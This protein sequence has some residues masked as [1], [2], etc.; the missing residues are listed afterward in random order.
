MSDHLSQWGAV[1][2][3]LLFTGELPA[4]AQQNS[5]VSIPITVSTDAGASQELTLGI[6]PEATT[7]IDSFLGE[8]ERPPLPPSSTFDARLI[9]DDL[10]ISGLGTG[11][12]TDFRPGSF[13]F[14]GTT[15]HELRYQPGSDANSVT[16]AWEMPSGVTGTLQDVATD[17]DEITVSMTGNGSVALENLSLMKLT[18]TLE[19]VGP[20]VSISGGRGEHTYDPP[21]PQPGTDQNP[22]GRL[23]LSADRDGATLCSLVVANEGPPPSGI[24][25]A[26]LWRSTDDRFASSADTKVASTTSAAPA[27]FDAIDLSLPSDSVY[28]FLVLSLTSEATGTYE[29]VLRRPESLSLTGGLLASV[30]GD[31]SDSFSDLFLSK[32]ATPLP[33]ELMAFEGHATPG[34]VHLTWTTASET[35][36]AGFRIQ[37]RVSDTDTPGVRRT[38]TQ[39]RGNHSTWTTVGKVDGAGTTTEAQSYQFADANLPYEADRLTYRLKQIDTDGSVH[40]SET[41]TVRRNVKTVRLLSADPNPVR[42]QATVR[43]ALPEKRAVSLRLFDVLG[44]E[45]RTI[46]RARQK[47]RHERRLDVRPLPSGTYVLQLRT[48]RAVRTQTLTVIQ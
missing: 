27:T 7:G 17:G 18:V 2:L 36:N 38:G 3:L 11:V 21:A 42:N 16:V 43:Y 9:D 22:V 25:S 30:G 46:V 34:T 31:A 8:E 1:A 28:V 5:M 14:E 47:G 4:Q 19:Y 10:S 12:V 37:R 13:G 48:E 23:H 35:N 29:P 15:E 24:A 20:Y 6:D 39:E 33:V 26:E 45:I 32:T 40:L 41:V 44:R